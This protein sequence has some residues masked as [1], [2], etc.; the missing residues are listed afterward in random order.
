MA[1]GG[2][3]GDAGTARLH[4]AIVP[5]FSLAVTARTLKGLGKLYFHTQLNEDNRSGT[6]DV[7]RG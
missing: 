7:S 6:G 5:R 2:A 3:G 1:C 4:V